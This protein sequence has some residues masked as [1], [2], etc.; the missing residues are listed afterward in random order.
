MGGRRSQLVIP[1]VVTDRAGEPVV[2]VAR[3]AVRA[4]PVGPRLQ[5]Y[6][7]PA[8]VCSASD[9][10]DVQRD[11]LQRYLH[12]EKGAAELGGPDV[13]DPAASGQRTSRVPTLRV[14]HHRAVAATRQRASPTSHSGRMRSGT[15]PQRS[16]S[17]R[18]ADP[19]REA[20]PAGRPSRTRPNLGSD[21]PAPETVV[22]P[23]APE[24]CRNRHH[25][26]HQFR[27]R[28]LNR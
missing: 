15:S 5:P 3:A 26:R 14:R 10:P 25:R 6:C 27:V 9:V 28:D 23:I 13:D 1:W 7:A 20:E 8:S 24:P 22:R 19:A 4:R 16:A 21:P 11:H 12:C 17:Q 2:P 18:S